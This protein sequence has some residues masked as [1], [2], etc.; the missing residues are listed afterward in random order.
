MDIGNLL[1]CVA[2]QDNTVNKD[3]FKD[4]NVL[5]FEWSE[6]DKAII[7]RSLDLRTTS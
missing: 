5:Q 3:Y 2:H 6:Y 7:Q 1:V 4:M